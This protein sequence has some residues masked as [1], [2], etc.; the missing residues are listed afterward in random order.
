MPH[1]EISKEIAR[2]RVKELVPV[3]VVM[4]VNLLTVVLTSLESISVKLSAL[5]AAVLRI[6]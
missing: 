2:L 5:A 6:T 1:K 4:I 3:M